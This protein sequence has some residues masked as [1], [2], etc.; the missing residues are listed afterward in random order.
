[1]KCC[2]RS[3]MTSSIASTLRTRRSKWR[4]KAAT[5][6]TCT[7]WVSVRATRRVDLDELLPSVFLP[8]RLLGERRPGGCD[9]TDRAGCIAGAD[10]DVSASGRQSLVVVGTNQSHLAGARPIQVAVS[11]G[12]QP[13]TGRGAGTV[14]PLDDLHERQTAP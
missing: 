13:A 6:T 14:A 8:L 4:S 1:N 2:A 9:G 10:D 11:S 3:C 12:Q 7:A 5:R